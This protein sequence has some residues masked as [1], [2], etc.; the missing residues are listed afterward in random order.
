MEYPFVPPRIGSRFLRGGDLGR[1]FAVVAMLAMLLA[2]FGMRHAQ[3]DRLIYY[4]YGELTEA[5]WLLI[6][7][8]FAYVDDWGDSWVYDIVPQTSLSGDP[9]QRLAAALDIIRDHM[10]L[11]A[12][13][14]ADGDGKDDLLVWVADIASCSPEGCTG[15]LFQRYGG[16]WKEVGSRFHV[17]SIYGV[18]LTDVVSHGLPVLL[19]GRMAIAWTGKE[20]VE[21]C[22]V[23]CAPDFIPLTRETLP[24]IGLLR[25]HLSCPSSPNGSGR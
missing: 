21:M 17:D 15:F 13:F 4:E 25:Q 22:I 12:R 14:D 11:Y 5:E 9:K 16:W 3:A 6:E 18:C 23:H 2:L 20:Y 7:P 24:P 10:L 1:R 8:K 19:F